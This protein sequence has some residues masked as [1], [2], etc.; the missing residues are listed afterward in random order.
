MD[1]AHFEDWGKRGGEE[2]APKFPIFVQPPRRKE[3][4]G[5][6]NGIAQKMASSVASLRLTE[7]GVVVGRIE[8]PLFF[9]I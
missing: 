9:G 7:K 8:N 6:D 4:G 1:G 3:R 2:D 5:D